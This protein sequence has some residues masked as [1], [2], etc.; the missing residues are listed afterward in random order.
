[1]S[2]NRIFPNCI[3]RDLSR[4]ASHGPEGTTVEH[5]ASLRQELNARIAEVSSL[6]DQV[7]STEQLQSQHA[8]YKRY[9]RNYTIVF[10]ILIRGYGN[11]FHIISFDNPIS[12][13]LL[14]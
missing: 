13:A 11:L 2:H 1:M 6:R 8:A 10:H 5:I 7:A 3:C 4:R 9:A 12:Y 14:S